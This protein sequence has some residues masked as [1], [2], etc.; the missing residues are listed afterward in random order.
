MSESSNMTCRRP[1]VEPDRSGSHLTNTLMSRSRSAAASSLSTVSPARRSA[2]RTPAASIASFMTACAMT[3]SLVERVELPST[4][5]SQ[6]ISSTPDDVEAISEKTENSW[7]MTSPPSFAPSTS[8]EATPIPSAAAARP[9]AIDLYVSAVTTSLPR[10]RASLTRSVVGEPVARVRGPDR[11]PLAGAG[12]AA[13]GL[14]REDRGVRAHQ[15]LGPAGPDDGYALGDRGHLLAGALGEKQLKRERRQRARVVVDATVPLGLAEN[16]HDVLG[17]E[18]ALIQKPRPL[19]HIV[20]SPH[21]NLER[22]RIH[23]R[24]PP[25][26]SAT[27]ASNQSQQSVGIERHL[28]YAHPERRQRIVDGLG[29]ERRHWNGAGLPHPF[30]PERVQRRW[31][32]AVGDLDGRNLEGG[33]N[34]EVHEGRGERLAARVVNDALEERASDALRD[35]PADLTLDDRRVHQ[36]AAVVLDDVTKNRE[37][38]RIDVHLDDRGVAAAGEGGLRRRVVAVRLEPGFFALQEHGA[39]PWLH[40][41]QRRLGRLLR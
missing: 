31:R 23:A 18:R 37:I 36:R 40:Q 20:G 21:P 41:P 15:A 17:A 2:S 19:A 11:Q 12:R 6:F 39:L 10:R 9:Y 28:A 25:G 35:A 3:R 8:P 4:M 13:I 26:G 14:S 30:D 32:L 22:L 29:D 24:S 38:A 34:Q 5:T 27:R 33:W 7:P 1:R 16:G